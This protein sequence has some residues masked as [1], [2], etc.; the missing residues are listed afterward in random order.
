MVTGETSGERGG[1][2]SRQ[3]ARRFDCWH[4]QRIGDDELVLVHLLTRLGQ[5]DE[6]W[7]ALRARLEE[8]RGARTRPRRAKIE[9]VVSA[10]REIIARAKRHFNARSSYS[11]A[12]ATTGQHLARGQHLTQAPPGGARLPTCSSGTRV[13]ARAEAGDVRTVSSRTP[14]TL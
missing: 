3:R 11:L 12:S 6:S 5:L 14:P 2:G 8:P 10:H 7:R 13:E 9:P 1:R 4:T